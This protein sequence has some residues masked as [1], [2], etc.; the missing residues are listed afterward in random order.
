MIPNLYKIAGELLD[1]IDCRYV[2]KRIGHMSC[3]GISVH[4]FHF[5]S[6]YIPT[7]ADLAVGF[8]GIPKF[9]G[10]EI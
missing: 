4:G 8:A 3:S 7:E 9:Y 1:R 2:S 10:N 6:H 5:S